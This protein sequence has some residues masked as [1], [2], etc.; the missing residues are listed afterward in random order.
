MGF[1]RTLGYA[2]AFIVL[3]ALVVFAVS[4]RGSLELNLFPLAVVVELP[5]Y[6]AL[7]GVLFV[8]IV[9]GGFAGFVSSYG[10]RRALHSVMRQ[11]KVPEKQLSSS[12][13]NNGVVPPRDG[14]G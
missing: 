13:G 3:V 11:G 9:V 14:E 7:I 6:L 12:V 5:I 4:N 10:A 2:I 1:V 8:G